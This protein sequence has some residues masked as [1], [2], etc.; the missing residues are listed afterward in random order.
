MSWRRFATVP[1]LLAL[2]T[3]CDL[4]AP[5]PYRLVFQ[6]IE[7]N[8]PGQS[9]PAI[10]DVVEELRNT[11][12]FEGYSL[13][14]QFNVAVQPDAEFSRSV[15]TGTEGGPRIVYTFR[16]GVQTG[17]GMETGDEDETLRLR[18]ERGVEPLLETTVDIKPGQT[19]VLGAAPRND[20]ATLLIVVRMV[21]A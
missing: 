1:L 7:A 13:A 20:D 17:I 2:P 18:V 12:Q 21:E 8:G 5:K 6:L 4:V 10:A 11:L 19:L 14:S 9:D 15:G 3:A 16:G